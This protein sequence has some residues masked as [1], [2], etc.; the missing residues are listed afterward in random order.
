MRKLPIDISTFAELQT[1]NYLYVDKTKYMY[2]MIKGGR[3]FFLSRPRR[4]GKSLLVSTLKEILTANKA[5]FTDLWI[6][7]SD[8]EWQEYGVINL[9]FSTFVADNVALFQESLQRELF[10]I[11]ESYHISIDPTLNEPSFILKKL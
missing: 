6:G 8:Y 3:R 1:S 4:F 2:H 9:D 11:A 10:T 5:L 7:Q